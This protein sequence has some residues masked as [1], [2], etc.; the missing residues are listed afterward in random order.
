MSEVDEALSILCYGLSEK[1]PVELNQDLFEN[2]RNSEEA[3]ALLKE[4][5]TLLHCT[6]E[7]FVSAHVGPLRGAC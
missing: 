3:L 7:C 4:R 2:S 6:T 1:E 5:V